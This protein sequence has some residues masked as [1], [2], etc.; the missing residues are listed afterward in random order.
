MPRFKSIEEAFAGKYTRADLM[1]YA[2]LTEGEAKQWVTRGIISAEAETGKGHHRDFTFWNLV[3]ACLA[4]KL[5]VGFKMQAG[6]IEAILQGVRDRLN[7]H[8]IGMMGFTY[9][10]LFMGDWTLS[11]I[12]IDGVL[13]VRLQYGGLGENNF[14]PL[15]A[16]ISIGM[17]AQEL[18]DV[19]LEDELNGRKGSQNWCTQAFYLRRARNIGAIDQLIPPETF[20]IT[21][22]EP[23]HNH[24][25]SFNNVE[26]LA[27]MKPN[28]KPISEEKWT[29]IKNFIRDQL[30]S[31]G[32]S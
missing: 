4:K 22:E 7:D 10:R 24:P 13:N 11:I 14:F 21:R 18:L 32:L 28:N 1:T 8:G 23:D 25:G 26:T 9:E 15:A 27:I 29:L 5:S 20:P 30:N 31:E 16:T 12:F 3:E 2:N 19:I 6:Q 17:A